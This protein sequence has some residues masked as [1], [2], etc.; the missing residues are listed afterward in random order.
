[1]SFNFLATLQEAAITGLVDEHV[2]RTLQ[3]EN[4]TLNEPE[5]KQ[6]NEDELKQK[7]DEQIK[8]MEKAAAFLRTRLGI[9]DILD[10]ELRDFQDILNDDGNSLDDSI[11]PL[12]IDGLSGLQ[13][14]NEILTVEGRTFDTFS[15]FMEFA[16]EVYFLFI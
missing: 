16:V 11:E 1:M 14:G 4:N 13:E 15:G 6:E 12:S 5:I 3:L 9:N 10:G 8:L 7:R 2:L